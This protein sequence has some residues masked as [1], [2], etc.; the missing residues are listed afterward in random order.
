MLHVLSPSVFFLAI[1]LGDSSM[2]EKHWEGE[3]FHTYVYIHTYIH[4]A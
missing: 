1:E 3:I 2:F 4:I